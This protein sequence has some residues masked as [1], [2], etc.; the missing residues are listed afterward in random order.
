MAEEQ[1]QCSF[2]SQ[3]VNL[4]FVEGNNKGVKPP[5]N[6]TLR[7]QG[8]LSKGDLSRSRSLDQPFLSKKIVVSAKARDEA[9]IQ[10]ELSLGDIVD[11]NDID[12]GL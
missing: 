11:Q 2:G 4:E 5:P 10:K 7:G 6:F 9:S 1:E 3:R 12:E 8:S